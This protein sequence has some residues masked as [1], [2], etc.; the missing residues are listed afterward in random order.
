MGGARRKG[1]PSQHGRCGYFGV[2]FDQVSSKDSGRV[3]NVSDQGEGAQ[4]GTVE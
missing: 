2:H 1:L 4:R 3:Q